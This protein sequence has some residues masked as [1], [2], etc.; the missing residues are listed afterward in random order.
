M[1]AGR[2]EKVTEFSEHAYVSIG[3]ITWGMEAMRIA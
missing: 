3:T 1:K 2:E